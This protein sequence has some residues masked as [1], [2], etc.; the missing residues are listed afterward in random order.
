MTHHPETTGPLRHLA[1]TAIALRGNDINTDLMM[2]QRFLKATTFA[3]LEKHVFANERRARRQEGD[4][5]PFDDPARQG[6]RILVVNRNFGYGSSR[7]HAPQGLRRWGIAAVVGESF[8]EIFA[9]NCLAIGVPCLCV[10]EADAQQLQEA[11]DADAT[12]L[13]SVDLEE[14]TIR[15][16]NLV[17]PVALPDGARARFLAGTWDATPVLLRAGE[18]IE[19][20]A[21]QLPYLNGW[22]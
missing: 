3:G 15:S 14:R 11:A 9:A 21:A 6:A 22:T 12:R 13:F 17:V 1:G 10:S 20:V 8:G 19:R 2:P 7:E 4:L 16:G 18:N 5:H